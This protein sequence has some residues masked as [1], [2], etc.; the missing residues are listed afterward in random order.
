MVEKKTPL[1]NDLLN[2][3]MRVEYRFCNKENEPSGH[4]LGTNAC[5]CLIEY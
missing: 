2:G 5:V 1:V 4:I 3:Y